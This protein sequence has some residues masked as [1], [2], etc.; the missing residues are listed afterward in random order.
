MANN[1]LSKY[2]EK[3]I[4]NC[5]FGHIM[6]TIISIVLL[7]IPTIAGKYLGIFCNSLLIFFGINCLVGVIFDTLFGTNDNE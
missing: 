2:V 7:S 1:T 4:S 3:I 5:T 6:L